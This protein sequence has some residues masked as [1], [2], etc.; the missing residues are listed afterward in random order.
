MLAIS[1]LHAIRDASRVVRPRGRC[2]SARGTGHTGG[3]T[4]CRSARMRSPAGPEVEANGRARDPHAQNWRRV[5]AADVG[6]LAFTPFARELEIA[7]AVVRVVVAAAGVHR[8][9][10]PAPAC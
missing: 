8:L 1:V 4:A 6:R 2:A 5:V 3:R 10:S 7:P 9:E